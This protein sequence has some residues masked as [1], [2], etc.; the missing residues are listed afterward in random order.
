MWQAASWMSSNLFI[1]LLLV[2][3]PHPANEIEPKLRVASP[4]AILKILAEEEE[5]KNKRNLANPIQELFR[6]NT[7]DKQIN[8]KRNG[9]VL[10]ERKRGSIHH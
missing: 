3:H 10:N 6:A 2:V 7:A 9:T 5:T 1:S 4:R 8:K